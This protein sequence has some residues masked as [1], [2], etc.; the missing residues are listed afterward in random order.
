M[1]FVHD[2]IGATRFS[3]LAPAINHMHH[4]YPHLHFSAKP[5]KISWTGESLCQLV[6]NM[7]KSKEMKAAEAA[8]PHAQA[9]AKLGATDGSVDPALASLFASSVGQS[10]HRLSLRPR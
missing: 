2:V 1:G 8:M 7:S 6:R 3:G 10:V 4:A 5:P 9:A